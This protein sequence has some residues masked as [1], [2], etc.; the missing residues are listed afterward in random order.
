MKINELSPDGHP[1]LRCMANIA[2]VPK[3]LYVRGAVPPERVISV[4][5]VGTRRPTLYGKQIAFDFAYNLA[6]RGVVIV[7]GLAFGIDTA[8]HKGALAAN[9][10]TIAVMAHGLDTVY[11]VAHQSIAQSILDGSGALISE[12]PAGHGPMKH[13]F[14][15]RNRL[16]SGIADAVVIIEAEEKS[17]TWSTVQSALEQNKEVFAVPGP[18]TSAQSRGPNRLIQQGAHPATSVDDI[19]ARIAPK[20]LSNTIATQYTLTESA[21]LQAIEQGNHHPDAISQTPGLSLPDCL[22]QLTSLELDGVV[23]SRGGHWLRAS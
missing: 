9:G 23:I 1:Y 22:A 18:I 15:E 21:I 14:L 16:V 10:V 3:I 13:R 19:L 17:G 11:P 6:K 7:S 5:I 4:A 20:L 2:N 12:Y 8:A